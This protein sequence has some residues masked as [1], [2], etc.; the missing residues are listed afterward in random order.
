MEVEFSRQI[1]HKYLYVKFHENLLSGWTDT[2]E[3]NSRFSQFAPK[4]GLVDVVIEVVVVMMTMVV[5]VAVVVVVVV[6]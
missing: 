1:F 2:H 4:N 5:V 3:A 6:L